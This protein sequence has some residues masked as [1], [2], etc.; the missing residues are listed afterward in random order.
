VIQGLSL[1]LG[2]VVASFWLLSFHA[3]HSMRELVHE[4]L[5]DHTADFVQPLPMRKAA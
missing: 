5:I 3:G 4:A 2:D 1:L